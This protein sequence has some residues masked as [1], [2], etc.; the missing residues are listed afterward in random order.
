METFRPAE[1]RTLDH[2]RLLEMAVVETA[3][4]P[5]AF[6]EVTVYSNEG[7]CSFAGRRQRAF[8]RNVMQENYGIMASLGG[9]PAHTSDLLS[10]LDRG[11]E[12]WVPDLQSSDESADDSP[13]KPT[14]KRL[15]KRG[16][17]WDRYRSPVTYPSSDSTDSDAEQ[18]SEAEEEK[19]QR[20][21]RRLIILHRNLSDSSRGTGC[22]SLKSREVCRVGPQLKKLPR[23]QVGKIKSNLTEAGH[24]SESTTKE[25]AVGEALPNSC[26]DCGQA[27]KSKL[28]LSNHQR[29]HS[30]EKTYKCFSCGERFTSLKVL[31]SHQRSHAGERGYKHP[32][33]AVKYKKSHPKKGSFQCP[34]CKRSYAVK[35]HLLL[36]QRSHT[37]ARPHKCLECG[38]SFIR[39]DHLTRH[40]KIHTRP[41]CDN[42]SK[43][44]PANPPKV[45]KKARVENS[46]KILDEKKPEA[47]GG[48]KTTPVDIDPAKHEEAEIS[49]YKCQF[50]GKCMRSKCLLVDHERI[51]REERAYKCSQCKKSFHHKQSWLTHESNHKKQA[52]CKLSKRVKRLS[53]K[54]PPSSSGVSHKTELSSKGRIGRKPIALSFCF[55]QRSKSWKGRKLYKCRYCEK[56]LST[57]AALS[58]HEKLHTGQK[59]YKC[60]EC[61]ESFIRKHHLIRHQANHTR[62]KPFMR[63]KHVRNLK[64]KRQLPVPEAVHTGLKSHRGLNRACTMTRR[65]CVGGRPKIDTEDKPFKCQYCGKCMRTKGSFSNHVKIHRKEKHNQCSECG[66]SFSRKNHLTFHQKTHGRRKLPKCSVSNKKTTAKNHT[67]SLKHGHKRKLPCVCLKCGD[68]F[69][70]NYSL[71]RHQNTHTG[72]KPFRCATCGKT[73]IQTWS[74]KRHERT[75]LKEKSHKQLIVAEINQQGVHLRKRPFKCAMCGKTFIQAWHLKR[76]EKTHLEEKCRTQPIVTEVNQ[77][78]VHLRK[79]PFKC[80]VCGKCF[81]EKWHLNR[82]EKIHLKKKCYKQPI[83]AEA[84]HAFSKSTKGISPEGKIQEESLV[85]VDPLTASNN[86]L[87]DIVE[88]KSK[89]PVILGKGSDTDT[90]VPEGSEQG[91]MHIDVE[92]ELTRKSKGNVLPKLRKVEASVSQGVTS[93]RKLRRKGSIF[94]CYG[95]DKQCIREQIQL[96]KHSKK[97]HKKENACVIWK[98]RSQAMSKRKSKREMQLAGKQTKS[99]FCQQEGTEMSLRNK[100]QNSK[101]CRKLN[102]CAAPQKDSHTAV[103]SS[104]FRSAPKN[105]QPSSPCLSSPSQK[106]FLREYKMEAIEGAVQ[107]SVTCDQQQSEPQEGPGRELR[108]ISDFQTCR[109]DNCVALDIAEKEMLTMPETKGSGRTQV[110]NELQAAAQQNLEAAATGQQQEVQPVLSGTAGRPLPQSGEDGRDCAEPYIAHSPK[111]KAAGSQHQSEKAQAKF[112]CNQ[113]WKSFRSQRHLLTHEK[114]HSGSRRFPCTQCEKSFYAVQSLKVHMQIHTGEKPFKCSECEFCCNVS[115]N[116]S[117][118][119][120]IHS[121]ERPY[122]C[123]RCEKS[124]WF[125]QSLA[126]HLEI[127]NK[128]EP[129]VGSHCRQA[130]EQKNVL[131]LQKGCK[132]SLESTELGPSNEEPSSDDLRLCTHP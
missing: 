74:L 32:G 76:H 23:S 35:N 71:S 95:Q 12:A 33:G 107:G 38:K 9:F 62:Q 114:K 116:L 120:R 20:R 49:L 111:E 73:F 112:V 131:K 22:H 124:F 63:I 28:S 94:P 125:S 91:E 43:G 53:A 84:N 78:G 119:K 101:T 72:Q 104:F 77:Q 44:A 42:H 103:S 106:C 13:V 105:C 29:I 97:N 11:E 90:A 87:W 58:N 128:K 34:V 40:Q 10:R 132:R 7:H 46:P 39:K 64:M 83:V 36:H 86:V 93:E 75:H 65:S 1:H 54:S 60:N 21:G 5:E 2:P 45:E 130:F 92:A 129:Y 47:A 108:G 17:W 66:K 57:N 51:H 50:C 8:C 98:L 18:E 15:P 61:A 70:D 96:R 85:N 122:P 67:S 55:T 37:L 16:T 123:R 100:S 4:V 48:E 14:L 109:I 56:L 31:A 127:H 88:E 126:I 79:R 25:M 117:R 113:C 115:S 81:I 110:T 30:R 41:P 24:G 6:V 27:F 80:T 26:P 52:A 102:T 19:P 68:R 59:P 118:H 121:R 99:C 82:H 69:E 3:Q 89:P